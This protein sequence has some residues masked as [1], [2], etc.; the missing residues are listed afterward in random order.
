MQ[1]NYSLDNSLDN[2]IIPWYRTKT[3]KVGILVL[4]ILAITSLV[5]FSNQIGDLLELFGLK[6][7]QETKEIFI[8]ATGG[9][10]PGHSMF[11]EGNYSIDP[12]DSFKV[13]DNRL[14]L[15]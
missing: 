8:D 14:M 7:A 4:T 10:E 15:N 11:F 6:A 9:S 2:P 12:I 5:L 1:K 3:F 13:E